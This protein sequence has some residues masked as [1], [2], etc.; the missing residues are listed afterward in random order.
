MDYKSQFWFYMFCTQNTPSNTPWIN[1]Y[2]PRESVCQ[3]LQDLLKPRWRKL[4]P[5][6]QKSFQNR[7]NKKKNT[8]KSLGQKTCFWTRWTKIFAGDWFRYNFKSSYYLPTGVESGDSHKLTLTSFKKT[9]HF[10][11]ILPNK[12][13]NK[14]RTRVIPNRARSHQMH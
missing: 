5:T 10:K 14:N 3:K 4:C 8:R 12:Y 11:Q 1:F 6:N 7:K 9:K 2:F 13:P